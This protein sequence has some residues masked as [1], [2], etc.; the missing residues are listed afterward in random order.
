MTMLMRV[1]L[2]DDND[3]WRKW[4]ALVRDWITGKAERP[5]STGELNELMARKGIT[6]Q[7]PGPDR[8]VQMVDYPDD[9]IFYIP[10]PSAR[11]LAEK[12]ETVKAGNYPLPAF[13]A[14]AFGGANE[15]GLAQE[16]ADA[17]ALRRIGEYTINMCA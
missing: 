2:A 8:P 15:A 10:L 1:E 4:G 9:G 11:M 13:Y 12:M 16:E 6:G 17:F 7:V 14:V 5:A 3:N